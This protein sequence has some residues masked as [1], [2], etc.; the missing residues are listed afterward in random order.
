MNHGINRGGSKYAIRQ[1]CKHT[2]NQCR[3]VGKHSR[4]DNTLLDALGGAVDDGNIGYFRTGAAGSRNDNQLMNLLQVCHAVVQIIYLIF[5]GSNSQHLG[6]VDNGAAADSDNAVIVLIA[7]FVEDG[8][9][10]HVGRL[11]HAV[12]FLK[13]G[14]ASQIQCGNCRLVNIFIGQNEIFCTQ[15]SFLRI[16]L[17]ICI[18]CNCR[19]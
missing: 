18:F 4:R 1:T 13:Q 2:R 14:M 9:Y 10:H 12:L 3:L 8:I 16:S 6:N 17:K 11:A 19:N 5:L 7:Q 15:T